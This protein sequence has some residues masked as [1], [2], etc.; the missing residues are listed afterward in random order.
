MRR[1]F[2]LVFVAIAVG[3]GTFS[4]YAGIDGPDGDG[5]DGGTAGDEAGAGVDPITPD[6]AAADAQTAKDGAAA[7]AGGDASTIRKRVLFTS[8]ETF[9][10]NLGGFNGA[11]SICSQ[12]AADAGLA[13][14]PLF[15]AALLPR[16]PDAGTDLSLADDAVYFR[17]DGVRIGSRAEL[18]QAGTLGLPTDGGL[19]FDQRGVAVADG[20]AVWTGVDA[21]LALVVSNCAQWTLGTNTGAGRV[22]APTDNKQWASEGVDVNCDAL[23]HIYCFQPY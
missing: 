17:A 8:R 6:G 16:T 12:L 10:G 11:T 20:K 18:A 23:V 2:W 14:G 9:N 15:Y 5:S 19:A 4:P 3:C 13:G 7:D 1:R 21:N 22:G